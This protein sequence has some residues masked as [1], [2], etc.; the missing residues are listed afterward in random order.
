MIDAQGPL[1]QTGIGQAFMSN[2]KALSAFDT[3]RVRPDENDQQ[4][5]EVLFAQTSAAKLQELTTGANFFRYDRRIA[6]FVW[7]TEELTDEAKI[8]LSSYTEVWT[9]SEYCRK[10]LEAGGFKSQLVPHCVNHYGFNSDPGEVFKFLTIFDS[11]SRILRKNPYDTVEAFYKAFGNSRQV[12]LTIKAKGLTRE[13]ALILKT[14]AK[15]ANVKLLNSE[16]GLA[17]M[18][19]LY[20]DHDALISLHQAEGFGLTVLEAMARGMKVIYTDYSAPIEF[21][22][23]YRVP[24]ELRPSQDGFYQEALVAFPSVE[25]AAAAMQCAVLDGN[26]VRMQAFMQSLNYS[27]SSLLRSIAKAY[28]NL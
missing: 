22:V 8:A 1:D 26:E 7:E 18:A 14:Y 3:V 15:D 24:F 4:Y 27:F 5:G 19:N 20:A 13:A 12:Q 25:Q 9:A 17:E 2:V 28:F 11:S 10:A 21:A 6:F 23:G 16:L